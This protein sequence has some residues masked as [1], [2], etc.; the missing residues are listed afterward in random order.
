[1]QVPVPE[2]SPDQ[3]VKVS[4][5]VGA[6]VNVTWVPF[7][8]LAEQV[9]PQSIPDGLLVTVP[10]PLPAFETVRV[11]ADGSAVKVAVTEWSVPIVS[12]HVPVP[13]QSPDHPANVLPAA[14]VA[15]RVTCVP[16]AKPT[17]QVE[18]QSIPTGLLVTEPVPFPAFET[19]SVRGD[20]GA[21]NVAVTEWLAPIVSVHVPVPEQSPV[22]PAKVLPAAGV[23]VRMTT[24][25]EVKLAEHVEPQLIPG[26]LLVTVPVPLPALDTSRVRCSPDDVVNVAVTEWSRSIVSVHVPVPAQSPDHPTNVKPGEA[27]AVNVTTVPLSKLAEQVEP[28]LIPAGLLT[29]MPLPSPAFVTVRVLAGESNVAPTARSWSIVSVQVGVVPEQSPVQPLNTSPAA[30]LAVKVTTVPVSKVAEQVETHTIPPGEIVTEPLPLPVVETVRVQILMK[31]AVTNRFWFIVT[32]QVPVPEHPPPDQPANRLPESGAAVKVTLAFWPKL[33]EQVE[34]QSIP[35]GLLVTVPLPLP[36]FETFRTGRSSNV[37]VTFLF[38]SIVKM[39]SVPEQS[40]DQWSNLLPGA[41]VAINVTVDPTSKGAKQIEGQLIP[42]G[43]LVTVPEPPPARVTSTLRCRV[44][45]ALT[46]WSP[47]IVTVQVPIPEQPPPDQP[48]NRLPSSATAVSVTWVP[49]SNLS[50]QVLPQLIAPGLLVTVP[51]PVPSLV[52]VRV[53][54]A[55]EAL[56]PCVSGTAEPSVAPIPE[57]GRSASTKTPR[58]IPTPTPVTR[59]RLPTRRRHIPDLYCIYRRETSEV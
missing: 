47:F 30:A 44:K 46:D 6:A 23:A 52:T 53:D 14:A 20:G 33:A 42:T 26:G 40:P 28:Q 39:Q 19:V 15:V 55:K 13:E 5:A 49:S 12:V 45:V 41:G 43:L 59:A 48:A 7:A 24:V 54:C 8:K 32:V 51:A 50:E 10:L 58:A 57:R 1:M 4:P 37:A 18:P 38:S 35:A 25:P 3:P 56:G 36:S 11:R 17:E 9:A 22:Q 16:G 2:Q 29:T 27:D 21:V 31:V 34:P